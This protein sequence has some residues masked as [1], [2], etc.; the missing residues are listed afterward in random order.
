MISMRSSTSSAAANL[1]S[2]SSSSTTSSP[3]SDPLDDV[4]D[5]RAHLVSV[6]SLPLSYSPATLL[7]V[8]ALF[9]YTGGIYTNFYYSNNGARIALQG[10]S[11]SAENQNDD[12]T[13]GLGMEFA[14]CVYVRSSAAVVLQ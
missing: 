12:S 3:Y 4:S 5:V 10:Q 7:L 1:S 6:P 11:L 8:P 14:S 13:F 9:R 2:R